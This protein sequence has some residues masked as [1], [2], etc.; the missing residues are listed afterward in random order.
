MGRPLI[1][2]DVPGC[3]EVVVSGVNGLLVK[4]RDIE[5]LTQAIE[6]IVQ[7]T[8]SQ[9]AFG[10]AGRSLA[11]ERFSEERAAAETLYVYRRLLEPGTSQER[12]E[13]AVI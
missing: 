9:H 13:P 11:L 7:D 5:G 4:P 12:P 6:R 8:E 3:R 1:A 2:T 10:V